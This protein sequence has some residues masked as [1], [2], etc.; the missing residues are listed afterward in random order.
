MFSEQANTKS[1]NGYGPSDLIRL[2][3]LVGSLFAAGAAVVAG[4]L[5]YNIMISCLSHYFPSN[6]ASVVQFADRNESHVFL[7]KD[8]QSMPTE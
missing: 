1:V 7:T 8:A 2:E 6:H 5:S 3:I 4:L